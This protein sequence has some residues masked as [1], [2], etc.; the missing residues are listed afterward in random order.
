MNLIC[1]HWYFEGMPAPGV[2]ES[3]CAA[4]PAPA[5]AIRSYWR[6]AGLA[7]GAAW[8]SPQPGLSPPRLIAR[9]S[10]TGCVVVADAR[11]DEPQALCAALRRDPACTFAVEL[12]LYA[13]LR[14]G[15]A[16]LE[17]IEG[18]FAFAI[19][20]PREN[21]IF[22]ARDR[23]GER[24]LYVHHAP[25]R[26]LIFGSSAQAVL[27]APGVSQRIN[28]ARIG[29]Y[30]LEGVG[31]GLEGADFSSTFYLDVQRHPPRHTLRVTPERRD[32]RCYWRLEPGRLTPLPCNEQE[33]VEAFAAELECAVARRLRG[34]AQY[35]SMLSGGLDSTTLAII[36][37]EQGQGAARPPLPTF[38]AIDG[39]RP[40]CAETHAVLQTIGLSGLAPRLLD[41]SA[42]GEL[43]AELESFVTEGF[44]EPFD[45]G[46]A[47]LDGQ[48]AA[49]ARLGLDGMIDGGNGDSLFLPG[50]ALRR[51][52]CSGQW[53]AAWRNA[54]GLACHG[55]TPW[56][57][58]RV[59][60]R[61]ALTPAWLRAALA[62]RRSHRHYQTLLQR[63]GI[64]L[65]FAEQIGLQS[66]WRQM[67]ALRAIQPWSS[68]APEAVEALMHTFP[69]A[70]AE[71]YYRIAARHG[72]TPLTP[73]SDRRLLE[74]CVELPD[75]Q[76]LHAGWSKPLL[77]RVMQ[78]RLP[79]PVRLRRDKQ[80]L[81]SRLLCRLW[82]KRLPFLR[83]HLR[84]SSRRLRPYLS[85]HAC[86]VLATAADGP[87]AAVL[88]R[89]W[90]VALELWL[91]RVEPVHGVR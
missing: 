81:G 24:P 23:M 41:I 76:R 59:P 72:I 30:L 2:I 15:E 46:M 75:V 56:L 52:L 57:H 43:R 90:M 74:L 47:L 85:G 26:R 33:W 80:H 22:L 84:A 54:R 3:L 66:R 17:R 62:E 28:P 29:D 65:D 60:L 50:N 42:P 79:E 35:G 13:W 1:G 73:F 53:C 36:A 61:S 40:G 38:S 39:S 88:E 69:V 55:G 9:H 25:G 68:P 20:D 34:A 70:G 37:A 44:E 27:A 6:G 78:G 63:A 51:Q 83:H 58:L 71:R 14:W 82:Q 49:A 21:C 67:Q 11:L 91:N 31:G 19:H 89:L 12:I 87:E 5:Q 10:A 77:R 45:A 86:A 48:Y 64:A 32:E 4:R 16:C 8:W 7:F 18:D